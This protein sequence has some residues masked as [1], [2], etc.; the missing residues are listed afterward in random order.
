MAHDAR[1]R[2]DLQPCGAR[3]RDAR[4]DVHRARGHID[5]IDAD[6]RDARVVIQSQRNAVSQ[7]ERQTAIHARMDAL[8][9]PQCLGIRDGQPVARI[10]IPNL[11]ETDAAVHLRHQFAGRM[12]E[13]A[14]E[15]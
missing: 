13:E 9:D 7:R 5:A 10:V 14:R 15:E 6:E 1:G 3:P 4:I 11:H 12:N 8:A 2:S